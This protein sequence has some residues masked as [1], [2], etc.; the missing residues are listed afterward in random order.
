MS[1]TT[2]LRV[3]SI[4]ILKRRAGSSDVRDALLTAAAQRSESGSAIQSA[5]WL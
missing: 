5:R 3:E 2:G 4:E 1:Q